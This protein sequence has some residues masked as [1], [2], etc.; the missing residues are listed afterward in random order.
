MEPQ[1]AINSQEGWEKRLAELNT[2]YQKLRQQAA[3][4]GVH[5][6]DA[7]PWT[8]NVNHN[9]YNSGYSPPPTRGNYTTNGQLSLEQMQAVINAMSSEEREVCTMVHKL[10]MDLMQSS[11]SHPSYSTMNNLPPQQPAS[12][13][14]QS[15]AYPERDNGARYY[16]NS[17]DY[18]SRNPEYNP[19]PGYYDP[20]Y[21]R[22]MEY[23]NAR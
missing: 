23:N 15:S 7:A 13:P 19:Y 11:S 22:N 3:E 17:Q 5:L 16:T 2:N 14:P 20:R 1:S 9:V 12:P 6:P 10:S 18:Y 4:Q 8:G 21:N